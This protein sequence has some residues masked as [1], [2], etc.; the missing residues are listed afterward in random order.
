MTLHRHLWH[1]AWQL[2]VA[3]ARAVHLDLRL[4]VH[5]E[6]LATPLTSAELA[7]HRSLPDLLTR[8]RTDGRQAVGVAWVPPDKRLGPGGRPRPP[9]RRQWLVLADAAAWA[10]L[11]DRFVAAHGPDQGVNRLAR[12]SRE[13]GELWVYH[14]RQTAQRGAKTAPGAANGGGGLPT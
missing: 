4:H 9:D 3:Q 11:V 14:Q 13:A 12:L 1:R 7:N 8:P 10:A 6:L 2:D 5:Y